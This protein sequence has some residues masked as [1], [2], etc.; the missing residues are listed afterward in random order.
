M[1]RHTPLHP[2]N[3]M[4]CHKKHIAIYSKNQT[5]HFALKYVICFEK[6]VISPTFVAQRKQDDLSFCRQSKTKSKDEPMKTIRNFE[7]M[8]ADLSRSGIKKRVAVVCATDE[9]T[10]WA[11]EHAQEMGLVEP[12]YIDHTDTSVAAQEAVRCVRAGEADLLMKGMLNSDTLLHAILDHEKGLLPKGNVLTH[13]GVA[14][15]PVYHKLIAYSDAAV[16][17]YPTPEQRVAQVRY[18]VNLC[19]QLGID[20]PKISLIHCSEKPNKKHFP[21]NM[22]YQDIIRMGQEGTFGPCI[23]DGPLDLQTSFDKESM[24]LKGITSPIAGDA[25]G[26]IFPDIE[27]GNTFHKTLTLFC[28]AKV[29]CLVQGTIAPIIMTSRGDSQMSKFLSLVLGVKGC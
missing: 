5:P 24:I 7:D 21:F 26:I 2:T 3:T 6:L 18:L 1:R 25:D 17:P 27:A 15:I 23:I 14:E 19:H 22:S 16:I 29:A 13:I 10:R 4:F 20:E 8:I 9:H 12:I 11:V 28:G